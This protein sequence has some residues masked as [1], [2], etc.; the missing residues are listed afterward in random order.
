[1]T[2]NTTNAAISLSRQENR[3]VTE[4]PDTAAEFDAIV[5]DLRVECSDECEGDE[6]SGDG[7]SGPEA[8]GS[9]TYWG[10]DWK[11]T[12]VRPRSG[13]EVR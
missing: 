11:V 8:R 9:V 6:D 5:D 3:T 4:Y 1:M 12:V 10:D 13:A 2:T 7:R